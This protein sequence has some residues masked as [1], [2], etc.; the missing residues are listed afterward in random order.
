M[1]TYS[2]VYVS[3]GGTLGIETPT[4]AGFS[5]RLNAGY[6]AADMNT[7]IGPNPDGLTTLR[8]NAPTEAELE[9][10]LRGLSLGGGGGFIGGIDASMPINR[11]SY[12][13]PNNTIGLEPGLYSPQLGGGINYTILFWDADDDGYDFKWPWE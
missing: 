1:D 3:V 4:L 13:N 2:N 10:H 6:I 8:S 12:S 5:G 7:Q 11:P 9:N